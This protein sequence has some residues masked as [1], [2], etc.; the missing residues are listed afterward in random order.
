MKQ[1]EQQQPAI[2]NAP[3][4]SGRHF[5]LSGV[6][7]HLRNQRWSTSPVDRQSWQHLVDFLEEPRPFPVTWFFLEGVGFVSNP[8]TDGGLQVLA[9]FFARS[10]DLK[11]L[12]FQ[13]YFIGEEGI[14]LI[15]DALV[16][17][18]TFTLEVL[19]VSIAHADVARLLESTRLK[20][21]GLSCCN[22]GMFANLNTTQCL[23]L[24]DWVENF[25]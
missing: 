20:R 9:G 18:N 22:P 11:E 8:A 23:M 5:R 15:G 14:H 12:C 19:Q 3:F 21:L 13:H 17:N 7:L 4:H 1:E 6:G 2:P 16:G 10:A 25:L 24:Y